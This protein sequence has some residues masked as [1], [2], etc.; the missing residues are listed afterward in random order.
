M[1]HRP[2]RIS[3]SRDSPDLLPGHAAVLRLQCNNTVR[4]KVRRVLF[5]FRERRQQSGKVREVSGDENVAGSTAETIVNPPRWVVRLK[6]ARRRE[7]GQG[8]ARPPEC[9]RR[10]FRA[11]LAA[12]PDDG[13]LGAVFCSARGERF[14]GFPALIRQRPPRVDLGTNGFTV[15][16]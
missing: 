9:F 11:E 14:D 8:V 2:T 6:V 7:V 5:S 3:I 15:V 4:R 13:R 1:S 12:V 10:L 16:N